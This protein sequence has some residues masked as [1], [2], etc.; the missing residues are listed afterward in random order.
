MNMPKTKAKYVRRK[1]QVPVRKWGCVG[2]PI[3]HGGYSLA[4]R[5]QVLGAIGREP[6]TARVASHRDGLV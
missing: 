6:I 2:R 5:D 4:I 1:P 3:K